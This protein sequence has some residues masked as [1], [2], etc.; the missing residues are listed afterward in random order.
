[1]RMTEITSI[2]RSYDVPQVQPKKIIQE[3]S[4]QPKVIQPDSSD[5]SQSTVGN[6]KLQE[7]K[8]TITD[9]DNLSLTFNKE[10]SFDYIGSESS[11]AKLDIQK[12]ISDMRRDKIFEEY[13]YFV[14]GK[15]DLELDND[16]DGT[17]IIKK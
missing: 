13:Q 8:R 15:P 9:L 4:E 7:V 1:M 17:F 12:A 5:H 2:P 16:M 3:S 14:G 10:E 11:L 6:D